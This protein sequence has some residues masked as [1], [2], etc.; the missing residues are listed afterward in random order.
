MKVRETI[1]EAYPKQRAGFKLMLLS[2][3]NYFGTLLDSTLT[4]V[5]P[6]RKSVV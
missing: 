6:D 3:E 4:P 1:K 5:F 2:N